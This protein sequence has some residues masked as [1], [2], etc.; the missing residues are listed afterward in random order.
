MA[1]CKAMTHILITSTHIFHPGTSNS[2]KQG[3]PKSCFRVPREN[4]ADI[5]NM[6]SFIIES[7]VFC[8]AIFIYMFSFCI[9]KTMIYFKFFSFFSFSL[10]RSRASKYFVRTSEFLGALALQ[11][12]FV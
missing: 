10:L 5:C 11:D 2:V 7:Q 1:F 3:V 4:P 6:I 8:L 12:K 9:N